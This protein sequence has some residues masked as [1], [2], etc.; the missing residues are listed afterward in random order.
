MAVRDFAPCNIYVPAGVLE[1][2]SEQLV[3]QGSERDAFIPN[4]YVEKTV[5]PVRIS[6]RRGRRRWRAL[7]SLLRC[8]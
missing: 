1:I 6:N 5:R 8:W 4:D 7:S 3:Q 2:G